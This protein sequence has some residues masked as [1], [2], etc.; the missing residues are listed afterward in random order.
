[1]G[2]LTFSVQGSRKDPY[3]LTSVGSGADFQLI[4]SCPAGKNKVMCKHVAYLLHG[5]VTKMVSCDPPDAMVRLHALSEVSKQL[6]A[7]SAVVDRNLA[8]EQTAKRE[9]SHDGLDTIE[10]VHAAYG[11]ELGRAGWDVR[12]EPLKFPRRGCSLDLHGS[13]RRGANTRTYVD[14][15]ISISLTTEEFEFEQEEWDW[16]SGDL[17]PIEGPSEEGA[18]GEWKPRTNPWTVNGRA[19]RNPRSFRYGPKAIEAFW[20]CVRK[21]KSIKG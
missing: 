11:A 12:I 5:D 10:A 2:S 16:A 9:D 18:K 3:K 19:V 17:P 21:T 13:Y 14:P 4:C 15:S 20:E 6:R 7:A 1:L 8:R